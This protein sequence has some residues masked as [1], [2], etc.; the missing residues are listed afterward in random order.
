LEGGQD[1]NALSGLAGDVTVEYQHERRETSVE[2]HRI[3][4]NELPSRHH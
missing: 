4:Q 3:N 2:G 1:A